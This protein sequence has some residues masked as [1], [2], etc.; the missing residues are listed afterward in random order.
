MKITL[1]INKGFSWYK[2]NF[3]KFKGYFY[4]TNNN[5]YEKETA[6]LF[7]KSI[8]NKDDLIKEI[9]AIN[10]V[11]T[12]IYLFKDSLFIYSDIT[13]SFPVFYTKQNNKLFLSDD[14]LYLKNKFNISDFDKIAEIELK[15]SAHV[16]GK[17]TLL[18][19]IYQIQA[20]EHLII[21][22]DNIITSD[23]LYSYATKE[24]NTSNY[25]TLKKNAIIAF[26]NSFKR[27]IKSFNNK[28]VAIPLSGGF[29]SRLIAV[30]L[31]KYNYKNV[32]C[33]TYGKK[34]SFEIKNSKETAKQL[35]FKWYFIEY[36]ENLTS[37]FLNT[38]EFKTY[39]HF[40]GKF[41]SMPNLQEY[42]AVKYLSEKKIVEKNSIFIPGYAG[43]LLGG[44]QIL[45][46]IP[47][48]LEAQNIVDLV[49]NEKFKNY[50]LNKNDLKSIKKS[51]NKHFLNIDKNFLTK[52][53][54]TVFEDFD[55][56]EKISK[57]IF[58]SANFYTFFEHQ[59]RFPYWDKELLDF[60][61]E[62]PLKHKKGKV[63]FDDIL[64]NNYFNKYH[65]YFEKEL[66]PSNRDIKNQ[67]IK[68]K[69]K[70]FLPNFIKQKFLQKND[71]VNYNLI[72]NKMLVDIKLHQ[73]K[74]NKPI[75]NYNQIIIHWYLF[76]SKNM[77]KKNV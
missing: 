65:V 25:F 58:N 44:S 48:N 61:K 71:W 3:V 15:S 42:F 20:S 29:D 1:N 5:F 9:L 41:S 7:F 49:I 11:F 60:F 18:K 26:E 36:S 37:N 67:R 70:P 19:H 24:E 68:N 30:M 13:R 75:K 72:T 63:F 27:L 4:D 32:I 38:A 54:S 17:K 12:L 47:E 31:K 62:L 46:V 77:F 57:Y 21:Q 56:K 69:I 59:F 6:L 74:I 22:N 16:Y 45:K 28:T 39:M 73:L 64:I 2:N 50:N 8:E 14:I 10:G 33:Y 40:A 55:I 53:P 35:G 51:L 66:Q 34:N 23:F 43:D 52:I 76:Y